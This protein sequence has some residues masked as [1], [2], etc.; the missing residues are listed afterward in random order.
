MR[1]VFLAVFLAACGADGVVSETAVDANEY[2][3][4]ATELSDQERKDILFMWEEEKLAR[5]VYLELFDIWGARV[6]SNISASEQNHMDSI[7]G[8]L[9]KY[10]IEPSIDGSQRASFSFAEL[11]S[12]YE[13][14]VAD[15][16]QSRQAA[17]EVGVRIEQLDIDDLKSRIQ[18][19]RA[20]AKLIY[21]RLLKASY[22]HLAAFERNLR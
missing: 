2:E 14:L 10:Q 15:G 4:Q 5:D 18:T 7:G 9:D 8:L 12:L 22:N 19:A 3:L 6:F 17:I 21:E 20:D 16:A 11:E 1:A 13:Q